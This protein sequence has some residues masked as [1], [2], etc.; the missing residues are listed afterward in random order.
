MESIGL[1]TSETPQTG[2]KFRRPLH[3]LAEGHLTRRLFGAMV[4]RIEALTL[5]AGTPGH[6]WGANS[7]GK[8][9][10]RRGGVSRGSL[11]GGSFERGRWKVVKAPRTRH[12]GSLPCRTSQVGLEAGGGTGIHWA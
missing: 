5:A 4:R 11:P 8:M 1:L 7:Y 6:W 10:R 9:R 3:L 2:D 12:D